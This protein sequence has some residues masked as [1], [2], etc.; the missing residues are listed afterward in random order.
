[1]CYITD[2]GKVYCGSSSAGDLDGMSHYAG[3]IRNLTAYYRDS[4][5]DTTVPEGAYNMIEAGTAPGNGFND[6]F[7]LYWLEIDTSKFD[8]KV[9]QMAVLSERD[10]NNYADGVACYLTD[11]GKVY[12]SSGAQAS[13]TGSD[14]I[15]GSNMV[16][17][18]YGGEGQFTAL[19][20]G[21]TSGG[22]SYYWIEVDTK[23]MEGI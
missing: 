21:T 23:L 17:P 5:F 6:P 15:D 20:A 9:V 13:G 22:D 4:T 1:M 19:S 14:A 3:A 18:G 11:K 12:C 8:G 10:T 16:A 2:L 7:T